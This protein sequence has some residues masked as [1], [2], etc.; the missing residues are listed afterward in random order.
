MPLHTR[1]STFRNS[2][3]SRLLY[4]FTLLTALLSLLLSTIYVVTAVQQRRTYAITHLHQL[5]QQMADSVRLPLYAEN[6]DHLLQIAELI[7][8]APE[9][10]SVVIT[11]LNGTVLVNL[12]SPAYSESDEKIIEVK[13]VLSNTLIPSVESALTGGSNSPSPAMIGKIRLERGTSDLSRETRYLVLYSAAAAIIFWLVITTVCYLVLRRVTLSFN[14]LMY[15]LKLM[16]EGD[17]TT[18]ISTL[19]NDEPGRA[20]IAINELSDKLKQRQEENLQLNKDLLWINQS[21]KEEIAERIQAEQ[22]VRESEQ[23]L[24][25]LLDAMPVGV[26]WAGLDGKLEYINDFFVERFGYSRE[27]IRTADDWFKHAYPDPGYRGQIAELQRSAL[28]AGRKDSSYTPM[29][30]SRVTCKD[31]TVRQVI[32]KLNMSKKRTVAILIDITDREIL[33]EQI[34]KAQKLESIGILAGGIAHNFNNALTGVLGFISLAAK[35]LDE[36]H[37]A[38]ALLQHAEK[39]TKKAAGMAKQLLTF[40]RGSSPFKKAVSLRKLVEETTALTLNGTKV[41]ALIRIPDSTHSVMADEDQL[42]Q[43]FSNI[44]INALQAMPDGGTISIDAENIKLT[45]DAA[46]SAQQTSYVRLTFTDEGHGIPAEQLNKV[47]DPYFTTKPSNTGLGL[48][49]VHSIINKLGGQVLVDSTVDQ[50]TTFTLILPSTGQTA[51]LDEPAKE[52]LLLPNKVI[53]SILVMDDEETIRDIVKETVGFLGYQVTVCAN[54]EEAV[55]MYKAAH[56]SG[57]PFMAVIL[58][59]TIPSGMGGT[60]AAKQ[61]LAIDPD[62]KLIVSSGFSFDPVMTEY[63]EYGFCAAVTKPY[64]ADELGNK[65]SLL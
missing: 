55:S 49:S 30:E 32:T 58:D 37:K 54:G 57:S 5:A 45:G 8:R 56:E 13:E 27:E 53:G 34:I 14:K 12:R 4:V 21:L 63:K 48:A 65:L 29:F 24:K 7:F 9:I 43:V 44:T 41:R 50:G 1:F 38:T 40:A 16:Q 20:A 52:Q 28:K 62:A 17:Y 59:L 2:F 36:S 15:G 61:I 6:N 35:Q 42:S 10:Q 3:Q 64:R 39:A 23:D 51:T 46:L 11:S 25:I 18:R 19:S 31:G 60:E 22:S 47:F 33:Q 26:A